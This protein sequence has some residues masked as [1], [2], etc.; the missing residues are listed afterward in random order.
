MQCKKPR[1]DPWIRKIPQRS[2]WQPIPVFLP[3][4]SHGQRRL[5]DY[6]PRGLKESDTTE[7]ALAGLSTESSASW[8]LP[9]SPEN[10]SQLPYFP[11]AQRLPLHPQ[12]AFT[13]VS[14]WESP[15]FSNTQPSCPWAGLGS[16]SQSP[17]ISNAPGS[18]TILA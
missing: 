12:P 9:L 11:G 17:L 1:F 5:A 14:R 2:E 6:R 8:E 4:K 13:A 10:T 15:P 7:Q 18:L 16:G 3:G